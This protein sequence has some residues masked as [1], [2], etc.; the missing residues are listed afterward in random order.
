MLHNN[1]HI[2]PWNDF[3]R[4]LDKCDRPKSSVR[5]FGA[6]NCTNNQAIIGTN[7]GFD[8]LAL[9]LLSNAHDHA[10]L[11]ITNARHYAN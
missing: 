4:G 10:D 9:L 8:G 11:S 2:S 3:N 6:A 5:H 7:P 1:K